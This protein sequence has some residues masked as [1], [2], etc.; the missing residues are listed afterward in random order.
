MPEQRLPTVGS[1]DGGWG[2]LLN[3]FLTKE[4]YNSG[5]DNVL[6][7]MHKTITVTAGTTGAGSAPLKFTSGSLMSSAEAGAMEFLTDSLY[8][9]ITSGAVRKTIAFLESPSFTTPS[10]GAATATTINKVTITPPTTSAT[11]TIADGKVLTSSNTLTFAGTDSTTITFQGTDTY[12]GRATTDTLT[13]KRVTPRITTITP[14]TATPTIN[15]DNC[16]SVTIP[17][18]AHDI[19]TMTTNLSGSPTN[20]QKLIFR[21]KDDSTP[22]AITWGASFAAKGVAL[23]TTTVSSKL[24]TVGF[25]Y[26]SVAGSWGCVA[27]AQE[28]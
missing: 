13:N 5:A 8:F 9:T 11:L 18:L 16:D 2:T 15:T 24:L 1:D 23:P 10:L 22:R 20:F 21:I 7:G 14:S 12:V 6:N 17:A 25:I 27:K 3:S 4:H 26:D 19:N 28:A